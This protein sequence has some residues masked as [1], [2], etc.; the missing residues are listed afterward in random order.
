VEGIAGHIRQFWERR[1]REQLAAHV[2]A[3]GEGLD[4]LVIEAEKR[5]R[6]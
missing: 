3:G 5:L 1:M 6:V 4:P 2:A